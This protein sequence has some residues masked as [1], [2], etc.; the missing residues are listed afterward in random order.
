LLSTLHISKTEETPEV[1]FDFKEKKMLLKGRSLPENAFA[2]YEPLL[3]WV[4][5][6]G[7]L[8]T[9]ELTFEIQLDYF[10]S[11]SGRFIFEILTILEQSP[12]IKNAILIRWL[13]EADDDLMIEKGEELRDL[14]DLQFSLEII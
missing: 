14:L 6:L 5:E 12:S 9:D 8:K 10:N 7:Q 2:F 3:V 13:C 4:K 1:T 11:S